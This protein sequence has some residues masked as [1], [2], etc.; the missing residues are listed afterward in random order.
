MAKKNDTLWSLENAEQAAKDIQFWR[1]EYMKR[2]FIGDDDYEVI[3]ILHDDISKSWRNY[4]YEEKLALA[5]RYENNFIKYLQKYHNT[6]FIGKTYNDEHVNFSS[7]FSSFLTKKDSIKALAFFFNASTNYDYFID[8]LLSP[9]DT[10]NILRNIDE[11]LPAPPPFH[12]NKHYHTRFPE[13][14]L[15]LLQL[16]SHHATPIIA[17][18]ESLW[19]EE[20]NNRF[21]DPTKQI[22]FAEFT[23]FVDFA[24][25]GQA[26]HED[27]DIG[28]ACQEIKDHITWVIYEYKRKRNIPLK[29]AEEALAIDLYKRMAVGEYGVTYRS[30]RAIGLWLWDQR[31]RYKTVKSDAEAIRQLKEKQ[32]DIEHQASE[33]RTL[34]RLLENATKCIKTGKVIGINKQNKKKQKV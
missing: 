1:A 25:M 7:D 20:L 34:K 10:E 6:S 32:L 26:T 13:K 28:V 8:D 30:A 29:K 14:I 19:S 27:F 3:K 17:N 21:G 2:L 22:N 4:L 12:I 15:T 24:V 31:Y 9:V 16:D 18:T 11:A 23:R 5:R 33:E